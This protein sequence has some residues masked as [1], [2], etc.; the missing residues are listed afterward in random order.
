MSR[1]PLM[2]TF[3][4]CTFG[5]CCLLTLFFSFWSHGMSGRCFREILAFPS[6]FTFLLRYVVMTIMA[7]IIQ[8]EEITM[9]YF[10]TVSCQKMLCCLYTR[11]NAYGWNHI[12]LIFNFKFYIWIV[13]N[14]TGVVGTI[15]I[16]SSTIHYGLKLV[17]SSLKG[18]QKALVP[19]L[20]FTI[21][22]RYC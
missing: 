6:L 5:S 16:W 2:T 11:C 3:H 18:N 8:K 13:R 21:W 9:K 20:K 17:H 22:E 1:P 4:S 14:P 15:R 19:A 12:K 10:F 7:D